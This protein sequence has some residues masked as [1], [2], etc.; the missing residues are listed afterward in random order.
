MKELTIFRDARFASNAEKRNASKATNYVFS[1]TMCYFAD[2]IEISIKTHTHTAHVTVTNVHFP[3][4]VLI[5]LTCHFQRML[6]E[7]RTG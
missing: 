4:S 5:L 1:R 7:E 3:S 2:I 6:M